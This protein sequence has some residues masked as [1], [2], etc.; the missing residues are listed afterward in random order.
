MIASVVAV[1]VF[2]DP[3]LRAAPLA[4]HEGNVTPYAQK[5]HDTDITV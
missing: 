5:D 2:S 3:F 1:T 4:V